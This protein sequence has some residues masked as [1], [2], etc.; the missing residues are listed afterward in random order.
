MSIARWS[1]ENGG[2]LKLRDGPP[3]S[4]TETSPC[5]IRK[6]FVDDLKA[7][8][9]GASIQGLLQMSNHPRAQPIRDQ[10]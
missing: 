4:L 5:Q 7:E 10:G 3:V 8:L 9:L 6:Y 1:C 2:L